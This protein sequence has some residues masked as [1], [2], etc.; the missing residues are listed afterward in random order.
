MISASA[1]AVPDSNEA[2]LG[3]M[4]GRIVDAQNQVLQQKRIQV[5]I[6]H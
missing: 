3:V 5:L 6:A 1:F 2:A 4:R